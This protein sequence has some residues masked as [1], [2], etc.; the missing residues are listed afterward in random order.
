MFEA[1]KVEV[2]VEFFSFYPMFAVIKGPNI[3]YAV[4]QQQIDKYRSAI[5]R[6]GSLPSHNSKHL[7]VPYAS[8]GLLFQLSPNS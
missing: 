4:Q 3:D 6:F 5:G 2:C 7:K 8:Y 1:L